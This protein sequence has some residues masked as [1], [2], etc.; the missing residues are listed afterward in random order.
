MFSLTLGACAKGL[1]YLVCLCVCSRS[2]SSSVG[3]HCPSPAPTASKSRLQDFQLTNFT[4]NV[5]FK[6]YGG[7]MVTGDLCEFDY[8]HIEMERA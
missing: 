8:R 6:S 4:E 5:L 7:L 3:L 2:M 1:W